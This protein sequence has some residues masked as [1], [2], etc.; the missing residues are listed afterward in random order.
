MPGH[1]IDVK[2]AV[3]GRLL[4]VF[5]EYKLRQALLIEL[6]AHIDKST[7][8]THNVRKESS[9][10]Y[11]KESGFSMENEKR[12]SG[13]KEENRARAPRERGRL[14]I[15]FG[16]AHN[17]GKTYAM[18]DEAREMKRMGTDVLVGFVEA[19]TNIKTL[20]LVT[21]LTVLPPM[22]LESGGETAQEFDLDAALKRRP[23]LIAVDGLAHRNAPCA[24][25][26]M[27]YQDVEE[28]LNAGIDV[29]TTLSVTEIESLSDVVQEVTG[30][31]SAETVP[32]ALF[33]NADQVT[34]IDAEPEDLYKRCGEEQGLQGDALRVLREAAVRRAA[35]RISRF[36]KRE[37]TAE[38]ALAPKILVC[39][40]AS[41]SALKCVRL[42]AR[43][44]EERRV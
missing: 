18:L 41:P 11:K 1:T 12:E 20:R 43:A 8:M 35:D 7:R 19:H 36:N 14:R 5:C 32:D 37:I 40:S 39:V 9:I 3:S 33:D 42:A 23:S 27:R 25:N 44:A 34:F 24:R 38:S 10:I 29:Y 4:L 2:G 15:F 6:T 16:Y 28:L 17:S 21:G 30:G 22:L 31:I 26:A 13:L